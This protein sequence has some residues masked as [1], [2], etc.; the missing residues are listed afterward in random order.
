MFDPHRIPTTQQN[1]YEAAVYIAL[2][3]M[4]FGSVAFV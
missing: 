1:W 4:I 2:L 3:V